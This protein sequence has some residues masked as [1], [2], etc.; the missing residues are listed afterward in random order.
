MTTLSAVQS[1]SHRPVLKV[2]SKIWE[3]GKSYFF[4][5]S[6]APAG[7][8]GEK[9]VYPGLLL[10]Y[11]SATKMYVPYSETASYGTGSDDCVG[12]L[13]HI[14]DCTMQPQMIAPAI[15]GLAIEQYCYVFG[16]ALGTIP[17]AAKS[18]VPLIEWE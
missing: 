9:Y 10:A 5:S 13:P 14:L 4:D 1:I 8:Y 6:Y 11:N 3:V 12:V 7:T 18:N 2:L 16:G 15:H 17:A